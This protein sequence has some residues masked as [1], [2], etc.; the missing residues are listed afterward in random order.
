MAVTQQTD[1][2]IFQVAGVHCALGCL[3]IQEIIRTAKGIIPI[4]GSSRAVKGI[5]NLRGEIVTVLNLIQ[6]FD[7]D[8]SKET[9]EMIIVTSYKGESIG[10]LVNE[11]QDVV[12]NEA[13]R[14][15]KIGTIPHGLKN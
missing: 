5:L 10:L 4:K 12:Q 7:L 14:H 15:E 13:Y 9:Q 6:I 3:D 1:L 11:V 2:I 8:A